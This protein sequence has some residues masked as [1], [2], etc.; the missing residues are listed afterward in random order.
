MS[1]KKNTKNIIWT[2]DPFGDLSK[3][4]EQSAAMANYVAEKT[5]S[6]IEPVY[7]LS[8]DGFNWAGDFS[9]AWVKKVQPQI[10]E[11]LNALIKKVGIKTLAPTIL[12][13]KL[14]SLTGDTKKVVQHA[15]KTGAQM[16]V[17]TTHARTGLNR[18]ILGSFA[19]TAILHSK[20]P[21]L[22]LNPHAEVPKTLNKTLFATDLSKESKRGFKKFLK[23]CKGL[24]SEIVIYHKLPDPI[25]PIV[26]TGVQMAGGGWVSVQQFL[27]NE[28][29]ER[30][31]ECQKMA[32]DAEKMGFKT[33]VVIDR[34]T[35]FVTD[36]INEEVKKSQ[37]QMV[38]MVSKTGPVSTIL[39]GS[40]GRQLTRTSDVPVYLIHEDGK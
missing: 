5:K 21:L 31:A 4:I 36:S 28:G 9:S 16:I 14:L 11:K 40:I 12:V 35:G 8:P 7:V 33:K 22:L 30:E 23:N 38:A 15:K 27:S 10:E 1:K 19:E 26:Q 6:K 37:V 32:K 34:T 18:F 17:L 20:V 29:K 25:E 2:V 3:S 13:H 39:I 24:V